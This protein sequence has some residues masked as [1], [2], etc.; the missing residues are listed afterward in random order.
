MT[1]Q[2]HKSKSDWL[3]WAL[4]GLVIVS[5]VIAFVRQEQRR[6]GYPELPIISTVGDFNLTNQLGS[7]VSL[8][9]L[10]GQ[11]WV[12]DVI[13]TRCPVQCLALSR[14]F[15]ELQNRLPKN[16]NVKL[17]SLTV[18]PDYDTPNILAQYGGKL[19]TDS[20]KWWFLTGDES[21]IRRLAIRDMK[22]VAVDK[23]EEDMGSEDDLFIHSTTFMIVD[24]R[25]NVRRIIDGLESSD[26]EEG[27]ISSIEET[28]QTIEQLL[29]E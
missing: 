2:T 5:I 6:A 25:G 17:V 9:D 28:L 12:A 3:V 1:E 14:K 7:A 15:V 4:L 10:K 29:Q 18:D 11:V 13:F 24:R 26:T 20:D 22:F 19:G 8:K 16:K 23:D 27:D 21:E